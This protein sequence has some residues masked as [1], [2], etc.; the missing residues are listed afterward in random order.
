MTAGR[1]H[2]PLTLLLCTLGHVSSGK[3][4]NCKLAHTLQ[5]KCTEEMKNDGNKNVEK[6]VE[7][8]RHGWDPNCCSS[9]L[10]VTEHFPILHFFS[11][12]NYISNLNRSE[13]QVFPILWWSE[14]KSEAQNAGSRRAV[15]KHCHSAVNECIQWHPK[16]N[17]WDNRINRGQ[18]R[19]KNNKEQREKQAAAAGLPKVWELFVIEEIVDSNS[20]IKW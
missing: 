12:R 10:N 3:N 4:I 8:I 18:G 15:T 20:S 2:R 13:P 1:R 9:K 6:P 14:N 7:V 11:S 19:M 17:T 5:F 16:I